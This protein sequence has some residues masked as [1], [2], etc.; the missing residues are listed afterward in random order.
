MRS[1]KVTEQIKCF[2]SGLCQVLTFIILINKEELIGRFLRTFY[3]IKEIVEQQTAEK[4]N[5][6]LDLR[7]KGNQGLDGNWALWPHPCIWSLSGS[8]SLAP[9]VN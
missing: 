2:L 4:G 8:I 5:L 7:N 3:I 1:W 6:P 9:L